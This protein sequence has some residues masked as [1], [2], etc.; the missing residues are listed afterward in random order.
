M[1]VTIQQAQALHSAMKMR[2]HHYKTKSD[3]LMIKFNL[4]EI[5]KEEWQ[6]ARQSIKDDNPYPDGVDKAE[7][8]EKI[9]Q[10]MAEVLTN[11]EGG[12]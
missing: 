5:T 8:L 11:E 7:A 2:E 3:P 12:A 10:V 9:D 4:G 1:A 6:A